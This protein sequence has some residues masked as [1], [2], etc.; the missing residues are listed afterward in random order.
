MTNDFVCRTSE[1][2]FNDIG[3]I[4]VLQL[5]LSLLKPIEDVQK[6]NWTGKKRR[7]KKGLQKAP[8]YAVKMGVTR[9]FVAYFR[10]QNA[11][12]L[13]CMYTS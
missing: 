3:A 2:I 12:Q 8:Y 7:S 4:E 5:L 9:V 11:S 6:Y 1:N 13:A 10:S